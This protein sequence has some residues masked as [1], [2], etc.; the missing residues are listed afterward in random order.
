MCRVNFVMLSVVACLCLPILP[1]RKM[2]Y[3]GISCL[4]CFFAL[5]DI[6]SVDCWWPVVTCVCLWCVVCCEVCVCDVCV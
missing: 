5:V 1:R 6:L 3:G 2:S 4:F